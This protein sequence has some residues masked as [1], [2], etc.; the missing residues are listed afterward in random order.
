MPGAKGTLNDKGRPSRGLGNGA[1][2]TFTG[3]G[4]GTFT[5][6]EAVGPWGAQGFQSS[7]AGW[8]SRR[9]HPASFH[10]L[11]VS[12]V[13]FSNRTSAQTCGSA[14]LSAVCPAT[15]TAAPRRRPATPQPCPE[16][17]A[18]SALCFSRPLP[19]GRARKSDRK[20]VGG[21]CQAGLLRGH[22]GWR[23]WTGRNEIFMKS[24]L[25]SQSR[26]KSPQPSAAARKGPVFSDEPPLGARSCVCIYGWAPRLWG[27]ENSFCISSEIMEGPRVGH[28]GLRVCAFV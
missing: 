14:H 7:A 23:R 27:F 11:P 17:A 16:D 15:H 13:G 5:G 24:L 2:G 18:G 9:Q 22:W 26:K 10:P 12:L 6:G 21:N 28:E 25:S 19:E 3:Q 8:S 20:T 4:T 1:R